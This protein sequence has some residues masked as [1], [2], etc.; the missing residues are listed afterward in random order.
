MAFHDEMPVHHQLLRTRMK[1]IKLLVILL[2][3]AC[4]FSACTVYNQA[5][6]KSSSSS[7]QSGPEQ[8]M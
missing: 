1:T 4:L 7:Q 3:T 5:P 2:A 6:P 8:K